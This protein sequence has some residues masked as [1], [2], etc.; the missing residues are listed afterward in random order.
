MFL[1]R[2]NHRINKLLYITEM[3]NIRQQKTNLPLV[4]WIVSDSDVKKKSS[5]GPRIKVSNEYGNKYNDDNSFVITTKGKT[6]GETKK[7]KQRDINKVLKF[8]ELNSQL[9][10]DYYYKIID[11]TDFRNNLKKL[12]K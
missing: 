5:H 2:V 8:V 11:D 12:T 1:I 3:A 6:I 10:I 4:I 7:I 9:I